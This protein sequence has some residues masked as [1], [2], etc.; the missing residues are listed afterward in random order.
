MLACNTIS[1]TSKC[2]QTY[3]SYNAPVS[4]Q[5]FPLCYERI[6]LKTLNTVEAVNVPSVF[7]F[8]IS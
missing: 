3:V 1:P 8:Q 6:R 4:Q 5:T 7:E 2:I